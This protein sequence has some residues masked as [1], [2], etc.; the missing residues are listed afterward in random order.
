MTC[1]SPPPPVPPLPSRAAQ[2]SQTVRK[3]AQIDDHICL[4][5]AGLTAD[6]RVLIN[7]AR[8]EAQSHRWGCR[9]RGGAHGGQPPTQPPFAPHTGPSTPDP[10]RLTRCT[11]LPTLRST[12]AG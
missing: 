5:F 3:I 1:L 9:R 11:S 2:V 12:R 10:R 4:A 7:K 8:I 6:A